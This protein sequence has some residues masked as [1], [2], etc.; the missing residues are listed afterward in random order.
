MSRGGT[1][2]LEETGAQVQEPESGNSSTGVWDGT[3]ALGCKSMG[4]TGALEGACI[5]EG[6]G[7]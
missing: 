3:G 6:A 1:G 5:W 4:G 7:A 2:A